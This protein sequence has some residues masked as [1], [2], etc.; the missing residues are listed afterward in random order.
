MGLPGVRV[1]P[2]DPDRTADFGEVSGKNSARSL[3]RLHAQQYPSTL[4]AALGRRLDP[5]RSKAL[6]MDEVRSYLD[7][8]TRE[9]GDPAIPVGAEVVAASVRGERDRE[10]VL[11]YSYR[12]ESGRTAKWFAEY[13]A[14]VLPISYEDGSDRVRVAE[15]KERGVV[16]S[17]PDV[18]AGGST[19]KTDNE[20]RRLKK[21][22]ERL[23]G[24]LARVTQEVNR[25]ATVPEPDALSPDAG[26]EPQE[27]AG[28]EPAGD[29]IPAA[30][31]PPFDGYDEMKAAEVVKQLKAEDTADVERQAILDYEKTHANRKSVVGAAEQSLGA[32]GSAD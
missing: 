5:E 8:L 27:P 20:N 16:M 2:L 30:E 4:L 21:E 18:S 3:V 26:D 17:D 28:D 22:L 10:Q 15:M 29:S 31:D 1:G 13:N 11:T 12:V 23:Q 19:S 9:N 32:R 24:E 7:G 6:D 14:D 25:G